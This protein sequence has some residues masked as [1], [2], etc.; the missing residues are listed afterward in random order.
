MDVSGDHLKISSN[1]VSNFYIQGQLSN[2]TV[3]FYSGQGRFEGE[4]LV[5]NSV[6]VFHRGSNDIIVKPMQSLSGSIESYGNIVVH[7]VPDVVDIEYNGTG[8][9]IYK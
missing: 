8:Q 7:G 5:V 9:V 6:N 4:N 1:K 2:L 3:G